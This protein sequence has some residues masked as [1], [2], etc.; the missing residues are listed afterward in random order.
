MPK[1]PQ[2]IQIAGRRLR[3]TNLDKVLYPRTGTTKRDVLDY[4]IAIAPVMLPY[5]EQRA[6]TRK[7]WP[8]GVGDNGDGMVFFQKDLGEGAPDWVATADITHKD[9]VNTYPLVNDA[10]TLAWLAQLA[11]LEIHVPQWRFDADGKAQRPDRLVFDLDP[12]DGVDLR[13]CARVAFLVRE[14]LRDMGLTAMP[15]TSGSKGIHV[16]AG[17]DGSLTSD[18]ASAVAKELARALEAQHPDSITSSMKKSLRPGKVFIDWSQNNA[19]KTTVA[20]YS[21]RG[22]VEPW[23]AAPRTWRELASPHLRQLRFDE[24]LQR[25]ERRGDPLEAILGTRHPRNPSRPQRASKPSGTSGRAAGDRLATYRSKRDASRTTE[26]MPA[27]GEDDPDADRDGDLRF[28]IQRHEARRLHYDFRLEHD[29]V[30][31]SWALPKGPPTDP[32]TNHLAV[33][34]E[35]HPLSYRHFEGEIPKGE[36]GGGTVTIWDS[37]TYELE[38][39]RDDEVIVTLHGREGG[40]LDGDRRFAL[41]RAGEDRGAPRWMIHLMAPRAARPSGPKAS[42]ARQT[43]TGYTPMLAET[44]RAPQLDRL[45]SSLWAVEMKWDG[46]RALATIEHGTSTLRSRSGRVITS[47][48]PELSGLA[49]AVDVES[50]VLDG[51]LVALDEHGA[52]SFAR[53]QQRLGVLSTQDVARARKRAPVSYLVF[54]VLSINGVDCRSLPYDMRRTLLESMVDSGT[55]L[56]VAVP[57]SFDG[58]HAMTMSRDLGL[59]GV[60]AKLR[61]STYRSGQRSDD[62]LKFPLIETQE[63]VVIGWRASSSDPSGLASLILAV[64]ASGSVS[65]PREP[66]SGPWRYAGRVGTGFTAAQRRQARERLEQIGVAEPV[67]PVPA[68]ARRDANWTQPLLVGEVT[69][70]GLTGTGVLRQPVW[71]GWRTDKSPADVEGYPVTA[72]ASRYSASSPAMPSS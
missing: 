47:E 15:A 38:K 57:S 41:F 29:G 59:E 8:D 51:E 24:V 11:S 4:Y 25:V 39:W 3:V 9:H 46:I 66:V 49:E 33:P 42:A 60:V 7:R 35:D 19:A 55:R 5:V 44:G 28:V 21:L 63:V 27:S 70:K 64:P 13:D 40:G 45:D 16:Y 71:R 62:W 50:A 58:T 43:S 52:P 12:G 26:P 53:L 32:R 61:T 23:V 34:T 2:T 30:L 6:A 37:G 18:D 54:D 36:Y 17:L 48:Y 1:A 56:P 14:V 20:P 10:A 67:A 22:R 68:E 72:D 31:V 65:S 69:S